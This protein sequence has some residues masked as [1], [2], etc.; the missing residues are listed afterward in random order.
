[1]AGPGLGRMEGGE[2]LS[3]IHMVQNSGQPL[4]SVCD[5]KE[6]LASAHF[7]KVIVYT[8]GMLLAA[9]N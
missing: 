5:N 6:K 2:E 9:S 4:G 7:N 8:L 3:C 1:M